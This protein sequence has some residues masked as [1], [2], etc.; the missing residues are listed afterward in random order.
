MTETKNG[1]EIQVKKTERESGE[2]ETVRL[3]ENSCESGKSM[4]FL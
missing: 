2:G 3:W 1:R 4:F